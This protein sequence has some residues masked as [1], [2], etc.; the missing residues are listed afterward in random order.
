MYHPE[1]HRTP[2]Q[3]K[4]NSLRAAVMGAND[5]IVSI[6]GLVFGVAGATSESAVI[7]ATG[8]AG[9]AAGAISMAVGEYVSV[10]GSRDFENALLAKEKYE[11]EHYPEHEFTELKKIYMEKG[12]SEPTAD[13]VAQELTAHDA[14]AAHAEAELKIDPNT[15]SN[16]IQAALASGGAFLAGAVIPLLAITLP[17]SD[18]RILAAFISVIFAL[19]L[20]G[21]VSAS[22]AGAPKIPAVLR[23]VVGGI[24]AMAITYG[25]GMLVGHAL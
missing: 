4:L 25:I 11:L 7:L 12:I 23:V 14:F 1:Y 16:P 15:L 22:A 19:F 13:T 21:F 9:I 17:A 6:A 10:S 20:T 24:L 5:G 18:I 3:P 8:I 2:S